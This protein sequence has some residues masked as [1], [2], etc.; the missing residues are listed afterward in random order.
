LTPKEK[1]VNV[2]VACDIA[3]CLVNFCSLKV[4]KVCINKK[5]IGCVT[6]LDT[7][8]DGCCFPPILTQAYEVNVRI[9]RLDYFRHPVIRAVVYGDD[10][11]DSLTSGNFLQN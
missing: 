10:G 8:R 1:H 5:Q 3:N 11:V 6:A 9:F 2:C 4:E 7:F